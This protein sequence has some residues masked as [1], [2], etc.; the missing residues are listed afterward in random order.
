ME[1]NGQTAEPALKE[2]SESSPGAWVDHSWYVAE[3]CRN[4]APLCRDASGGRTVS[5]RR[6]L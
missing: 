4:N 6:I 1:L 5:A 2:A 3:V